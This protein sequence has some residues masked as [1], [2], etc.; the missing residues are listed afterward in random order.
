MYFSANINICKKKL[1]NK[2]K[3]RR[4]SPK[5]CKKEKRAQRPKYIKPAPVRRGNRE[6]ALTVLARRMKFEER[7]QKKSMQEGATAAMAMPARSNYPSSFVMEEI[8][9]RLSKLENLYF[10]R[11]VQSSAFDPSQ[12]KSLL[13]DLFSRDIPVFL[14]LI[15]P[16]PLSLSLSRYVNLF[17]RLHLPY[18]LGLC[19]F[20]V[21]S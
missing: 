14:G 3:I 21:Y 19:S 10:P 7:D 13:L 17:V 4:T 15:S 12:R 8:T 16:P 20:F 9:E 1:K 2:L 11:A 6:R 18:L 5:G